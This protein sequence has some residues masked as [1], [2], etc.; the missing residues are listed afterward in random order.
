MSYAKS[1]YKTAKQH[2]CYTKKTICNI[3]ESYV[4]YI[5]NTGYITATVISAE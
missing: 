3:K 1:V 2:V 5:C 4:T